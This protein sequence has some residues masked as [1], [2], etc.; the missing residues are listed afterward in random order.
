M[1][2]YSAVVNYEHILLLIL[3]RTRFPVW[4]YST[5]LRRVYQSKDMSVCM[6]TFDRTMVTGKEGWNAPRLKD[7]V[8]TES[9]M[10]ECYFEVSYSHL[11]HS[12]PEKMGKVPAV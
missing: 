7:A 8:V 12:I 4:R 1:N 2:C 5:T 6:L 11:F 9:K 3:I 10:R